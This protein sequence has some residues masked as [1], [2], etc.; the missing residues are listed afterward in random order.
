MMTRDR[1]KK[2]PTKI[3]ELLTAYARQLTNVTKE[4]RKAI[5]DQYKVLVE[6]NEGDLKN[7]E[8]S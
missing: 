1:L 7:V 8:D 6:R 4:I 3:P 5:E 2:M